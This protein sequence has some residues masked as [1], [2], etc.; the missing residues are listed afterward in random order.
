MSVGGAEQRITDLPQIAPAL[1]VLA[2]FGHLALE[3]E[4][5][6]EGVKI[7]AVIT[8]LRQLDL[9]SLQDCRD[10][11][12]PDRLGRGGLDS[13]H[14]IPEALGSELRRRSL[15]PQP[16]QASAVSQSHIACLLTGS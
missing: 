12:L 5:V 9:L 16:H 4:G 8:N 3:I 15:G 2:A 1:L 11:L 14:V 10:E 6:N 7:G 13:V